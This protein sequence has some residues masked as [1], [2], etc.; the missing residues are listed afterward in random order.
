MSGEFRQ[1]AEFHWSQQRTHRETC[2][3][4]A[5]LSHMFEGGVLEELDCGVAGADGG[6]ATRI[7]AVRLAGEMLEV[8]GVRYTCGANVSACSVHVGK[9]DWVIVDVP[10]AGEFRFRPPQPADPHVGMLVREAA[11]QARGKEE[12]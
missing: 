2:A 9:D 11:A 1:L 12:R 6:A 7:T 3:W 10:Q 5:S 4:L 8:V